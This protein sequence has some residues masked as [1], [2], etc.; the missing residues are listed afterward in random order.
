MMT[1]PAL[2]RLPI[3]QRHP[4]RRPQQHAF[5]VVRCNRV[6]AEHHLY[7]SRANHRRQPRPRAA[8]NDGRSRYHQNFSAPPPRLLHLPRDLFDYQQLRSLGRN[9]IR[10]E[11][12]NLALPRPFKRHH[13]DAFMP[14]HH[15]VALSHVCH[16]NHSSARLRTIH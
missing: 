10:H 16:R 14:H 6:S 12:K 5:H 13:P 2:H 7:E 8:V 3:A 4:Q 1:M 11:R 9:I 15:S